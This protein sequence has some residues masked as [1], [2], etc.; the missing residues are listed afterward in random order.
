MPTTKPVFRGLSTAI[1]GVNRDRSGE[2]GSLTGEFFDWLVSKLR[3][4]KTS[5]LKNPDG[6]GFLW[7]TDAGENPG[8]REVP[9][10]VAALKLTKFAKRHT[11]RSFSKFFQI[12]TRQVPIIAAGFA[13]SQNVVVTKEILHRPLENFLSRHLKKTPG[14]VITIDEILASMPEYFQ[15]RFMGFGGVV[16]GDKR[17]C[18]GRRVILELFGLKT[19]RRGTKNSIHY[20]TNLG[21]A[22]A[23]RHETAADSSPA[24]G[25]PLTF[26]QNPQPQKPNEQTIPAFF[27]RSSR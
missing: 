17:L 25:Q 15:E 23:V 20:Y 9:I 1:P 18:N 12:F 14:A 3:E 8:A 24:S 10:E 19:Q 7:V 27:V 13:E 21:L 16:G 26:P 2:I 22:A 4:E 5:I 11:G 6:R